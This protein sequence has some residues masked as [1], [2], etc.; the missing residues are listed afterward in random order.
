MWKWDYDEEK[1][2]ALSEVLV[3]DQGNKILSIGGDAVEG[4]YLRVTGENKRLIAAAPAMYEALKAIVRY[5]GIDPGPWGKPVHD[6]AMRALALAEG[7][8]VAL[9]EGRTD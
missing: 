8:E 5:V 2:P 9:A 6:V 4:Y 7:E 3:D 1:L